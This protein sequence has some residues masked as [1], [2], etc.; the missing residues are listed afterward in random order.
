MLSMLIDIHMLIDMHMLLA[1]FV[2]IPQMH[3]DMGDERGIRLLCICQ[4]GARRPT[5][6]TDAWHGSVWQRLGISDC[7]ILSLDRSF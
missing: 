1:P 3:T 4:A 2:L 7:Q 5:G 6:I